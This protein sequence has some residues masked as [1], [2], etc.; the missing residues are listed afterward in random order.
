[1]VYEV[2]VSHSKEDYEIAK[3]LK[4]ELELLPDVY[5]FLFE[6]EIL[7]NVDRDIKIKI[8]NCNLFLTLFSKHSSYK[9]YVNQEIGAASILDKPQFVL[10]I[11]DTKIPESMI[12]G[13]MRMPLYDQ[14]KFES[15]KKKLIKYVNEKA[16]K[17]KNNKEALLFLMIMGGI[18]FGGYLLIK[19]RKT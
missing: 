9:P 10:A 5:V 4:D 11:D 1:M 14:S 16:I 2:F 17:I 19:N 8:Q 6:D 13:V 3:T 15:E 12:R 18:A 7:E